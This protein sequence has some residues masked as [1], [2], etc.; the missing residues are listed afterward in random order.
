MS[1]EPARVLF[2]C[3]GNSARSI[4]A[5]ALA[6][7]HGVG[8]VVA[9]S[10]G[11]HPKGR[12]NPSAIATLQRHGLPTAGLRSKA[13]EEFA[14]PGAQAIDHV[15]TVCDHAAGEICPA[16]PGEPAVEHWSI[17][18]PA[19]VTR[20][21]ESVRDAFESAYL[22]LERRVLDLLQRMTIGRVPE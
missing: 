1:R 14:A 21:T 12:V 18:D 10:A 19:A 15:I 5:E 20:S 13:W 17:P 6:N 2:I 22:D 11:S 3:T 9:L 8:S 4:L 7:H 16:W